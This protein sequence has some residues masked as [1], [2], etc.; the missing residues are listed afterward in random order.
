MFHLT[1]C[2]ITYS[3]TW[4]SNIVT[5]PDTMLQKITQRAVVEFYNF[6][7]RFTHTVREPHPQFLELG[8]FNSR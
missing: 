6:S 1:S 5:N 7:S 2:A 8:K 4:Y 3:Q